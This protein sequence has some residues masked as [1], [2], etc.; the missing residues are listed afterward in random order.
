VGG[1]VATTMANMMKPSGTLVTYGAMTN[2]SISV[3]ALPFIFKDLRLTGFWL[4]TAI[5]S[6]EQQRQLLDRV[7]ELIK[8]KTISSVCTEIPLEEWKKAFV[9]GPKKLLVMNK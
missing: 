9:K 3:S 4:G 5:K 7:Q 8:S 6:K 2:D 1:T